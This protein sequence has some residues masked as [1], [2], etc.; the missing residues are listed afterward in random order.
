M[1]EGDEDCDEKDETDQKI[2]HDDADKFEFYK[3]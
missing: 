1:H 3:L 2:C